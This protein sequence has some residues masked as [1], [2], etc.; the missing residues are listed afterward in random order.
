MVH[1]T[2]NKA[3]WKFNFERPFLQKTDKGIALEIGQTWTAIITVTGLGDDGK[4]TYTGTGQ[5]KV[6]E[7]T[8]GAK[9]M[10][11][12]FFVSAIFLSISS[13]A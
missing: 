8:K 10:G 2:Q 3:Y 13:F 6:I 1:P 4:G 11:I 12:S 9:W 7:P 5:L